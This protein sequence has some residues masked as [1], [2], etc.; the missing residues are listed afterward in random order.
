M[1]ND[2]AEAQLEQ[3]RLESIVNQADVLT[4]AQIDVGEWPISIDTQPIRDNIYVA[5]SDSG[6]VSVI[7]LT[8]NSV[9]KNIN[10]GYNPS[11]IH[12]PPFGDNIYVANFDSDTVS[13]IDS[14]TDEV[15]AGVT[16]DINPFSGGQI[17]CNGL[18][19]PINR[20]FYVS[21]GTECVAKPN[22]GYELASWVEMFDNNSTR[23]INASTTSGSLWTPFLDIFGVKPNDPAANFTVNRFGNFTAYFRALPPPVPA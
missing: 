9:I 16:F 13:V 23:T 19:V 7:D 15:V 2:N 17:I 14:V 6:T 10:V 21:S 3:N 12:A 11:F 8:T 5:N 22:N 20:H 18:D 4:S 1:M